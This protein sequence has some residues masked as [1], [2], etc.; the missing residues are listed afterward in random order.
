[1][2]E[3]RH[4][5]RAAAILPVAVLFLLS[6]G[7]YWKLVL[8]DQYVWFDHPDMC[9]LE[10]PRLEF[11][12]REIHA[13]HFPLWDPSI[14]SGQPLVGQTQ[15]GPLYPLNLLFY[16][17]P[18]RDGYIRLYFLNWYWVVIKFLAALSCYL[19]C[20]DLGR[21][22][23][24]S[25][26][27]GCAFGFGGFIGTVAWLDV[28]NGAVWTPLILLYFFRAWRGERP[29]ASAALS[30][31]WLGIAWLCGHHEIPLMVS[32][33]LL[34]G[35]IYA[36]FHPTSNIQHPTSA[37]IRLRPAAVT[38]LIAGLIGAVQTWPTYEFGRISKR[39]VGTFDAV[40]WNDQIP[41]TIST[42]YSMPARGLLGTILPVQSQADSTPYLGVVAVSVALLGLVK[43]WYDARVRWL[44]ALAAIA[45]AY[46]MGALTP[47]Q[48][49][50][51][52]IAPMLG[53]ARVPVRAIHLL[54]FAIAVLTAYGVDTVL[55]NT[56]GLWTRRL[57][58]ALVA[59]G[60]LIF[61]AAT[62]FALSSKPDLN[63]A[64]LLAGAVSLA[65]A[66]VI[67]A[68]QSNAMG[69]KA[70]V[71]AVTALV[72]VEL[73]TVGT[74]LFP[75]RYDKDH[76]KFVNT[77][78]ENKD[79]V[80]FLRNEEVQAG[81]TGDTTVRVNV[82]D[83]E[84]P[85][86]FGDLHG[87]DMHEG[88]MAGVTIN[89][90]RHELH[91][92]RTQSLFGVTHWIG[93]QPNRPDMQE[94]F[95]GLSGIKVWRNPDPMPR[96][97]AVHQVKQVNDDADLRRMV[98]D[99]TVDFHREAAVL[100]EVPALQACPGEDQVRL[101]RRRTD[102]LTVSAKLSCTGMV[103]LSETYYPGWTATV[104]G[105]PARVWEVWGALRG[106]L[107]PGGEHEVKFS[108]RPLSVYAGAAL[109]TLGVLFTLILVRR[110][111]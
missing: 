7:F 95:T 91:T 103:I 67:L 22:R 20:R 28:V 100:G 76:N 12:A 32:F 8:T 48:G 81:K 64:V 71:V 93:R 18:L 14:W 16:L 61:G 47:L 98:Q 19:L 78:S 102:R 45:T 58:L 15:P 10:I 41:Y 56:G 82:N 59:F 30:G 55:T 2:A 96:V 46:S 79:I 39:W 80:D 43:G 49:V 5:H 73:Y 69:R 36:I 62:I 85:T 75:N 3:Q 111:C 63:D 13:W 70:I 89:L 90:L 97:W 6:V 31:F 4:N 106:V 26:V 35:W 25:I 53:K 29:L 84:I 23:S 68:R 105:H 104:D 24:A 83:Q 11:Q 77:L 21:S 94:V 110:K 37:L 108:Y 51:Y 99:P 109:T 42:I 65:A 17:L 40:A 60:C 57:R 33:T 87:I 107:V 44:A 9:Y 52:S 38:F 34:F 1:V 88:Y 101:T 27:A 86:N 92:K 66:G 72:L 74:G 54:N 50:L